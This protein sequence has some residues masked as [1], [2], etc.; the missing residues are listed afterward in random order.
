MNDISTSIAE[1][2]AVI[3]SGLQQQRTGYT[4]R[5][6]SVIL[7]ED[8]LVFTLHDALTPAEKALAKSLQGIAQVQEYHRQLFANS[9]AEMRREIKRITGREV[10]EAAVEIEPETGAVIHAF[11]SGTM[12]QVYLLT[13]SSSSQNLDSSNEQLQLQSDAIERA[14]NEG[15]RSAKPPTKE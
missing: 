6:V 9:I 5:A 10:N 7:H 3:A 13:K 12:V 14:E 1:Q 4:P 2:L 15:L 8:T 11:T